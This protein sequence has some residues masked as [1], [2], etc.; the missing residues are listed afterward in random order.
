MLDTQI[1]RQRYVSVASPHWEDNFW[2][3]CGLKLDGGQ[4]WRRRLPGALA[5]GCEHGVE[6]TNCFWV[7][8]G[9]D[10]GFAGGCITD[11]WKLVSGLGPRPVKSSGLVASVRKAI[12]FSKDSDEAFPQ[13]LPGGQFSLDS[14]ARTVNAVR[15]S[16]FI[17]C[18]CRASARYSQC[19]QLNGSPVNSTSLASV[20]ARSVVKLSGSAAASFSKCS[21]AG[22]MVDKKVVYD[23][24]R[25]KI[26]G[27]DQVQ[28]EPSP[29]LSAF[30]GLFNLE[31]LKECDILHPTKR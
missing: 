4:A 18:P 17:R 13:R 24:T 27:L 21:A 14:A 30:F 8:F 12:V 26:E 31:L 6:G 7:I 3:I 15:K 25:Q 16:E 22:T 28:G 2:T 29:W 19:S 1:Q 23:A 20:S 10:V 5:G 11:W 9:L